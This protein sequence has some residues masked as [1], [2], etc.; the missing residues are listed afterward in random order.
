M[1]AVDIYKYHKSN[2]SFFSYKGGPDQTYAGVGKLLEDMARL[3][4][5]Q[6]GA[7]LVFLVGREEVK[8]T[9]HKLMMKFR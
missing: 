1:R 2:A 4:E 7:D 8:Y 9:A 6:D 5:D 3:L